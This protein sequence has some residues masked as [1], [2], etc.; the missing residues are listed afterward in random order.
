MNTSLNFAEDVD[1]SKVLW[2]YMDVSKLLD[3]LVTQKLVFPRYDKF[4]DVYEGYSKNYIDLVVS[5]LAKHPDNFDSNVLVHT[6][7]TLRDSIFISLYYS[8]VSCWHL[9]EYESAGMW[10]LYCSVNESVAIKTNV[11]QLKKSIDTTSNNLAFG[12]VFY[13]FNMQNLRVNNLS[14]VNVLDSLMVKR[15]SFDHEKEYRVIC[16]DLEDRLD[17]VKQSESE[18]IKCIEF[19]YE[20][21]KNLSDVYVPQVDLFEKNKEVLKQRPVIK[22]IQVDPT[23]LIEEIIVAP[24]APKWFVNTVE[25][26]LVKLGY[27]FPVRQSN[28]YD[29]K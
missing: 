20:N 25:Q 23:I 5:E 6:K 27:N 11:G 19:F 13:D 7:A 29:L 21:S 24:T 10:K 15:E 26:L 2:R 16:L 18:H 3:L 4:E 14:N 22:A 1:D 17:Y 12:K 8:Y 28:L 9:N